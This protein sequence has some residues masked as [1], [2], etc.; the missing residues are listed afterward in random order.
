MTKNEFISIFN[1][2]LSYFIEFNEYYLM[3]KLYKYCNRKLSEFVKIIKDID[4]KGK[5]KINIQ[6]LI[7]ALREKKMIINNKFNNNLNQ[8][9]ELNLIE[10]NDIIDIMQLIIIDMKKNKNVLNDTF[11]NDN[12]DNN[13]ERQQNKN[14]RNINIYELYYESLINIITENNKSEMPLY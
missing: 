12:K 7:K 10:Q 6:E 4:T 13:T 9:D 8:I 2:K 1:D 11:N 5:G 14:K 3:S